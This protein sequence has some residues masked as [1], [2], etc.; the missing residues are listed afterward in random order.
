MAF[1]EVQLPFVE[2][3]HRYTLV[4]K[5]QPLLLA[6]TVAGDG[7]GGRSGI[8]GSGESDHHILHH[9]G[10]FVVIGCPVADVAIKV[11]RVQGAEPEGQVRIVIGAGRLHIHVGD[12]H[13][14]RIGMGMVVLH[15]PDR[16][17]AVFSLRL[18]PVARLNAEA[19]NAC[20]C[21]GLMHR[22]RVGLRGEQFQEGIRVGAVKRVRRLLVVGQGGRAGHRGLAAYVVADR[23]QKHGHVDLAA[24]G[25]RLGRRF[26]QH[27]IVQR[28]TG[29]GDVV[30]LGHLIHFVGGPGTH[31]SD[32]FGHHCPLQGDTFGL[33]FCQRF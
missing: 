31:R 26:G 23:R 33:G 32:V 18:R 3:L 29:E 11:Q 28:G 8:S 9:V 1:D 16:R 27:I 14:R 19:G 25:E 5:H 21:L 30:G 7:R 10:Q 24:G 13:A 20:D 12:Y 15:Q 2:R 17:L 6:R 22:F 4:T